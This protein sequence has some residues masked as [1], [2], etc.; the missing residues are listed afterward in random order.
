MSYPFL[1]QSKELIALKH[2]QGLTERAMNGIAGSLQEGEEEQSEDEWLLEVDSTRRKEL[3]GLQLGTEAHADEVR[4]SEGDEKV[5]NGDRLSD[6]FS[7][8]KEGEGGLR[9][10]LLTTNK[11]AMAAEQLLLQQVISPRRCCFVYLFHFFSLATPSSSSSSQT[12][13]FLINRLTTSQIEELKALKLQPPVIERARQDRNRQSQE[14]QTSF[15]DER[16]QNVSKR[17]AEMEEIYA[18]QVSSLQYIA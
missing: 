13:T 7:S 9:D 1:L 6:K 17:L 11:R 12:L 16:L 14:T 15:D 2:H 3:V 10:Q 18:Q 8:K 4:P 5:P